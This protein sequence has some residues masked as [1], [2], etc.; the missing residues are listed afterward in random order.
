MQAVHLTK[1]T[2]GEQGVAQK[3][4][5][6]LSVDVGQKLTLGSLNLM[7]CGLYG[8]LAHAHTTII[9]IDKTKKALNV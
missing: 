7:A 3:A 8:T 6:H 9:G 4:G 2:V 5:R 1:V